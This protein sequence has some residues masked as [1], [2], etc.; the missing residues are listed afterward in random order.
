MLDVRQ[1]SYRIVNPTR[2]MI[3]ILISIN[4]L[5]KEGRQVEVQVAQL[6]LLNDPT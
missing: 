3:H 6:S 4:S 2:F 5:L 1:I